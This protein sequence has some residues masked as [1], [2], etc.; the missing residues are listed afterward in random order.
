M[1]IIPTEI[2]EFILLYTEIRPLQLFKLG[3][4][5]KRWN[6]LIHHSLGIWKLLDPPNGS[7]RDQIMRLFQTGHRYT[8]NPVIWKIA[9][10]VYGD[11]LSDMIQIQA[12]VDYWETCC[13]KTTRMINEY[14]PQPARKD[15]FLGVCI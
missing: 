8:K 9:N 5:C 6:N 4:V 10:L 14:F 12:D 15:A 2:L 11:N 7:M 13:I 1:N 3:P